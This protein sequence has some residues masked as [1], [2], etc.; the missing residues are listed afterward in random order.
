MLLLIQLALSPSE[1]TRAN[2]VSLV[3]EY[4]LSLTI[5]AI[6]TTW[7]TWWANELIFSVFLA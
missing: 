3:S 7:L 5:R 4:R 6:L 1:E 2:G